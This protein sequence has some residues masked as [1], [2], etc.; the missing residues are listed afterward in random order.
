MSIANYEELK[1]CEFINV[2]SHGW[3]PPTLTADFGGGYGAGCTVAPYGLHRWT[4]AADLLP[5]SDEYSID[6]EVDGSPETAPRFSYFFEFFKRH[7]ML[8]NKP[9][10]IDTSRNGKGSN[11]EWCNPSGRALGASPTANTGDPL[12][13]AF[14]W[15]KAPGES[16]GACNGGPGAGTFWPEYALGLAQRAAY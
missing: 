12:V 1:I 15:L 11:G 9:F 16:D 10:V 13:D 14:F 6:Y 2:V 5:D 7:L 4:L 8:G 3:A